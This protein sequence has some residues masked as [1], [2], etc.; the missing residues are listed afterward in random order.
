MNGMRSGTGKPTTPGGA[1]DGLAPHAL[2][3]CGGES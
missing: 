1:L 3:R 2:R